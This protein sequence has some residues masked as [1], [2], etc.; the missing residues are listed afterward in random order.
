MFKRLIA[1]K[2]TSLDPFQNIG[3]ITDG[4]AFR[5]KNSWL[6]GCNENGFNTICVLAQKKF[7]PV[8][9]SLGDRVCAMFFDEE[10]EKIVSLFLE[11]EENA[12]R[13]FVLGFS[14]TVDTD[15]QFHLLVLDIIEYIG[16]SL[17]SKFYV[18][19]ATGYLEHQSM[20][21]LEKYI[22]EHH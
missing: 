5:Q 2:D 9:M 12:N 8:Q 16:K 3:R 21:L 14:N 20:E 6:G 15:V 7:A 11:K 4:I 10:C 19:D 17:G 13:S 18:D 1:T 22:E